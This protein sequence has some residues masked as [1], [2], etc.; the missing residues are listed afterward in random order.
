MNFLQP[1]MLA[2]LPLI[3]L[4]I[5]IHLINQRRFQTIH[6]AAM[7]FLLAAQRMARGYSRLRQWLILCCR[8]LA[9]AGLVLAVSRPMTSGWLGLAAGGRP[10]TTLVLLDRSP[11]MQQHH[12]SAGDS[13]FAT[14]CRQLVPALETLG[15]WHWALIESARNRPIDM[16]SP[17]TLLNL[18]EASPASASADLPAMLQAAHQYL[19]DNHTGRT[20]L[21]ICSDL[22]ANDWQPQSGRWQALRDALVEI[23]QS[24]R[25]HLL[26]YPQPASGNVSVRATEVRRQPTAEGAELLVSFELAREGGEGNLTVAVQFELE[27]ARSVIDVELASGRTVVKNHRIPLERTHH[28]GWGRISIPADANPA[29]NEFFF[30][31]DDPPP[32]RT[33]VVAEAAQAGQPLVLA[34]DVS[35]EP[36]LKVSATAAAP[37]A[38]ASIPW[39]EVALV[40]WQAR[41]P[42]GTAAEL[43]EDLVQR[44]GQVVCFPPHEPDETELFGIRWQGWNEGKQDFPVETWRSDEDLLVRTLDGAAL[45][46]GELAVHRYCGMTGEVIPLASLAGGAPL[47]ARAATAPSGVYFWSTTPAAADSSLA[48][49]GVVLYAS[50]QRALAAGA[51]VLGKARMLDAG[52]VAGEDPAVWRRLAGSEDALSTE[53]AFHSGVYAAGDRLLAVNRRT[54]E[55]DA[56]IVAPEHVAELFRGLD[57]VRLD[58]QAGSLTSLVQEIWRSFLALMLVALVLEAALCLP[59]RGL[60]K[61]GLPKRSQSKPGLPRPAHSAGAVP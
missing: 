34:A 18:P 57:F 29:D 3:A 31:F 48:A 5:I 51:Q 1:W 45:P 21:W 22:R 41:L 26:A 46:L 27:G 58:G 36:S 40:L 53:F 59:K 39:N 8:T 24:V 12:G 54:S 17:A 43:L 35:P 33:I 7:M 32:R 23:P 44:G 50:V 38:L 13:K 49:G 61:R 15:S 56:R 11:S 28:R 9:V 37:D 55:D 20:E 52:Q 6:W 19:R 47:L 16:E 25:I 42:T 60:P 30:V 4:P 14:A 10:D 2:A